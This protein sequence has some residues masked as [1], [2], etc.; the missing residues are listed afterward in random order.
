[1]KCIYPDNI[2]S[3]SA[4]EEDANYL[5]ANLLDEHPKKLWKG[6]SRDAVVILVAS[7]GGALAVIA[8]NATS[9]TL[10][11]SQGQTWVLDAGWALDDGWALD[12][13]GDSD[14][15][16]TSLLPGTIKGAAWFDFAS[17]RTSSFTAT[18]TLTAAA[19]Q[20]VQAGVIACG[21]VNEFRDPAQGIR[22]GRRDYSIKSKELNNGSFYYRKRDVVRVFRFTFVEDR[23]VDFYAFMD[24]FDDLGP[25]PIAWNIVT[26]T[27]NSRWIVFARYDERIFD[28]SHDMPDYSRIDG[29]I[30][31]EL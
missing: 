3:I 8:T 31:E 13:T 23:D 16:E 29:S 26:D 9:I 21:P 14:T 30:V 11:L 25:G 12:T 19:G 6:T 4:D 27:A 5:A 24:I 7:S 15:T 22:E 2:T 10:V 17:E 1:M 20:I 28:G 18:L